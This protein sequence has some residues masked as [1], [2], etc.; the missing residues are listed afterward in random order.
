MSTNQEKRIYWQAQTIV[1]MKSQQKVDSKYTCSGNL[2]K[3][4]EN[5]FGHLLATAWI[6]STWV[7]GKESSGGMQWLPSLPYEYWKCHLSH[8]SLEAWRHRAL[9][10]T[11]A[12]FLA[13]FWH[14]KAGL[15]FLVGGCWCWGLPTLPVPP[16]LLDGTVIFYRFAQLIMSKFLAIN[17]R[18]LPSSHF[19]NII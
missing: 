19:W 7:K 9:H 12:F 8:P 5:L 2:C 11:S 3:T 13:L 17:H 14:K 6:D 1:A 16:C 10:E 15:F 4:Q 18:S